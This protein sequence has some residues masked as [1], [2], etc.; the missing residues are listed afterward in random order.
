[1]DCATSSHVAFVIL[2]IYASMHKNRNKLTVWPL[3]IFFTP[4]SDHIHTK[5]CAKC[6]NSLPWNDSYRSVGVCVSICFLGLSKVI[7]YYL[8]MISIWID[9]GECW[10]VQHFLYAHVSLGALCLWI[11]SKDGCQ[12]HRHG[13]S[14]HVENEIIIIL[15]LN[16]K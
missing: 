4:K 11:K 12:F 5:L 13:M 3:S 10:N 7:D 9:S 1:M 16:R 2:T 14:C 15:S 8:V 6:T